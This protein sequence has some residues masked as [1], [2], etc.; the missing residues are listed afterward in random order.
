M[1]QILLAPVLIATALITGCGG[2]GSDQ[3]KV[4]TKTDM[5]VAAS[6]NGATASA[7]YNSADA[8]N[9]IDEDDSTAWVSDSDRAIVVDFG[10]VRSIESFELRKA[11]ASVI[12]GSNPDVLIELSENGSSYSSSRATLTSGV[13]PCNSTTIGSEIISCQMDRRNV[14]YMRITSRN[15]KAFEFR[16]L[17]VIGREP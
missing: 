5:N 13:V 3:P 17:E 15:G 10:A 7:T 14:R 6:A 11:A 2:G 4:N 12:A 16:E 1:R 8:A 9:L